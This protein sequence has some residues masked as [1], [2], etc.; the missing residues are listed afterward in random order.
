MM[1]NILRIFADKIRYASRSPGWKRVRQTHI[2]THN[3]CA[4]CGSKKDLEV[5]HIVP[6]HLDASLELDTSNL[7]TLCSKSCHL[8][9]GHLMDYRSWNPNVVQDCSTMFQKISV[10]PYK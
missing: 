8:L 3:Y 2:A 4:A 7:I 1:F 6:V 9:F 5:H 10:R